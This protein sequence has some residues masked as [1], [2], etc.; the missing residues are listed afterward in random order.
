MELNDINIIID[1]F[2]RFYHIVIISADKNA[3][4]AIFYR[5]A[6][7]DTVILYAPAFGEIKRGGYTETRLKEHFSRM[8]DEGARVFIAGYHD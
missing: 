3:D 5:A 8:I 2:R 6:A 4:P 7:P 1:Y